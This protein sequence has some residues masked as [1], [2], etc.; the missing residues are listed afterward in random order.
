MAFIKADIKILNHGIT[1]PVNL[2]YPTDLPAE[3]GNK[4]KGV[5]TLLHGFSNTGSDWM[6]YTSAA[7]YAA[8][9][10]YVLVAPSAENSFYLD[11]KHGPAYHTIFTNDLPA[12]LRAIFHLPDERE[13]NFI[14]GLSMGGYGAMH[15]GLTQP[16]RYAAIGSFSGCLDVQLMLQL[17][18]QKTETSAPFRAVFGDELVATD[19]Q[20]LLLLL[21]KV[22]ALT[23]EEQPR[24][25]S[26]CGLQ[27]DGFS[28]ILTMCNNFDKVASALPLDYQYQTWAGVHEFNFWDRSLAEFISFIQ[29]SD[30]STKKRSDWTSL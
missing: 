16:Q 15:L 25:F 18:R 17:A 8:D 28:R 24:L 26:T 13:K 12:Q 5:I 1:V 3:V 23:K 30:Y 4:I 27:D 6:M 2:Y 10:G 29:N 22:A 14:A 11:M 20:D 9:N 19:E 21:H 7:R